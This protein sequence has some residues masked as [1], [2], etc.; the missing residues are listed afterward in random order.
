MKYPQLKGTLALVMTGIVFTALAPASLDARI[1]ERR[2]S[3]ER[4]LTSSGG[5][6]YR[7]D[8]IE[9]NRRNGMPYMQYLELLEGSADVRI[10]YKTADGRKPT[11]SELEDKRMN[12]GWDVHVVYVNGKSVVEVYKRSQGM[13]DFELN[14]LIA[15]QGSGSGWKKLEKGTAEES[16]FG[17]E[18]ESN[19]GSV[20]AKK[21][22]ADRILF[23]D[24]KVD[25]ALAQMN[26][27]DLQEKAPVSVNGF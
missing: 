12:P 14:Q 9:A 6:V 5:V 13:S 25:I 1:G 24:A 7:D 11:S 19:D 2:D 21:M 3:L 4:R 23:V 22:G 17:Y 27:S 18:M 26:E 20:R 16:A 8:A 10:Y 15:L